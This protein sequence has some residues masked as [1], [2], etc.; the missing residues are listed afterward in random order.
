MHDQADDLRQLVRQRLKLSSAGREPGLVVLTGGK[1]GVGTTTVAVNLAITLCSQVR[2]TV[3]VDADF[4]RAG[5]SR[6]CQA[7]DSPSLLDVLR[8]RLTLHEVMQPGPGGI[9]LLPGKQA[10][11]DLFDCS[12]LVQQK[13]VADLKDLGPQAD[14]VV[15]D[16]GSAR[17]AFVRRLWQVADAVLVVTLPEPAA[18][19][20][21][22]ATIKVLLAGDAS[23]RVHSVINRAP[24]AARAAEVHDRI[25]QACR[26]FLGVRT[27]ALGQIALDESLA[28]STAPLNPLFSLAAPESEAARCMGR[29]SEDL[30]KLLGPAGGEQ[31]KRDPKRQARSA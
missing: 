27:S 12:A 22:Y 25:H 29:L 7:A 15:I 24:S 5:A 21:A 1:Q 23:V 3:L 11:A 2:R 18:I 6:L 14:L 17:N 31:A 30:W 26:R 8:G 28:A 16:A 9:Q 4:D 13:W 20:D 10:C 19:M